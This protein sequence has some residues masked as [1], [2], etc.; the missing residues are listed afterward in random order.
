MAKSETPGEPPRNTYAFTVAKSGR[1]S[2]ATCVWQGIEYSAS[3]ADAERELARVMVRAGLPDGDVIRGTTRKRLHALAARRR[4]VSSGWYLPNPK[5][6]PDP[7]VMAV[8][9]E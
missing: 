3:G 2:T 7:L 4:K 6:P 8:V 5:S 1:A 9:A